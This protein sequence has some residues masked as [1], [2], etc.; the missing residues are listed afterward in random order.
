[1]EKVAPGGK[2]TNKKRDGNY[3]KVT[4]EREKRGKRGAQGSG[5][6]EV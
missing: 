4:G 2:K 5:R 3:R 1:M 6:R